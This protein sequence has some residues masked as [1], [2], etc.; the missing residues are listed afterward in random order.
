MLIEKHFIFMTGV[1]DKHKNI[2]KYV[3]LERLGVNTIK[4]T[5]DEGINVIHFREKKKKKKE[6]EVRTKQIPISS[7][8]F[9]Y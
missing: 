7:K 5:A 9:C 1:K 2:S 6:S 3:R 4:P 8:T